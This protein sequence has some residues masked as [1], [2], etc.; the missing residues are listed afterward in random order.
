MGLLML[1][2]GDWDTVNNQYPVTGGGVGEANNTVFIRIQEFMFGD[3]PDKV[4]HFTATTGEQVT[5][6]E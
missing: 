2:E 4:I 6:Y 1:L 3:G 5:E